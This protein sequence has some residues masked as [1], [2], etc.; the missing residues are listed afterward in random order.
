MTHPNKVASHQN[1][2]LRIC[3]PKVKSKFIIFWQRKSLVT[4]PVKTNGL[5]RKWGSGVSWIFD[6]FFQP[7][8]SFLTMTDIIW[9]EQSF[10][11]LK[12]HLATVNSPTS[13]KS[14]TTFSLVSSRKQAVNKMLAKVF[15]RL[16]LWFWWSFKRLFR[17]SK[18]V[19]S[20][21]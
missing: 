17:S 16:N 11:L 10:H 9:L 6:L 15:S 20:C 19:K 8:Y 12:V 5:T 13:P 14:E 4:H 21:W 18:S 7:T 1:F 2:V 3:V